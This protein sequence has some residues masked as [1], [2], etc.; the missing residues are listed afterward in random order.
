MPVGEVGK[1]LQIMSG[2][3]TMS[4]R[5]KEQFGGLKK[6]IE[7]SLYVFDY[8]FVFKKS[9]LCSTVTTTFAID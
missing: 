6:A 5:V 1:N 3:D 2:S 7:F 9:Y 8:L 4:K